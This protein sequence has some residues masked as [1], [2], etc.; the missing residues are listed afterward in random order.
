MK[1]VEIGM[2]KSVEFK[3]LRSFVAFRHKERIFIKLPEVRLLGKPYNAVN[4]SAEYF[5]SFNESDNIIPLNLE[6]CVSYPE[7]V[8]ELENLVRIGT[9]INKLKGE[10]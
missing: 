3:D 5:E 10:K 2:A 1:V 7:N 6:I 9:S 8:N 4:I